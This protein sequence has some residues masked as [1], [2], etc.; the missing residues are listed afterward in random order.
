MEYD[1]HIAYGVPYM[2]GDHGNPDARIHSPAD[3]V[4]GLV[5]I[6]MYRDNQVHTVVPNNDFL[7]QTRCKD[8]CP[9]CKIRF[10]ES[11]NKYLKTYE[12]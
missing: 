6:V 10:L 3:K 1:G 7:D 12:C 5:D 4:F 8:I 2:A 9:V 11:V